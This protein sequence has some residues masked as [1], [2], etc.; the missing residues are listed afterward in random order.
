METG[1]KLTITIQIVKYIAIYTTRAVLANILFPPAHT[2]LSLC[3][4]DAFKKKKK[5]HLRTSQ[6][7]LQPV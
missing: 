3:V 4:S 1:Q 7:K 2:T 6:A 5:N